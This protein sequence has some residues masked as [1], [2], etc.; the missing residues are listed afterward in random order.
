L[1]R[2]IGGSIGVSLFGAIFTAQLTAN[3]SAHL[4]AGTALP[5]VTAPAAILALPDA[6]RT[7]YLDA[8][9][10]ALHPVF[11]AATV[12]AA[13]SFALTWFVKEVPLRGAAPPLSSRPSPSPPYSE[14]NKI[15]GG[16]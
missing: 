10:A 3:L 8:F 6:V 2:S 16:S 7:L 4:A 11:L 14:G 15:P 13:L 1:F 12:F 9:T 5:D